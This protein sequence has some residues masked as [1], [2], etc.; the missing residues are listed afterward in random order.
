VT[1]HCALY[2]DV[3]YMMAAM[4]TRV[5][6]TSLRS[7]SEVDVP[8]FLAD[9][10][11]QVVA[12]SGLPLLRINWYDAGTRGG[13]V[14]AAQRAIGELPKVKL[15][16]GRTGFNG[17]QKGVDLKLAL[18]LTMQARNQVAEVVY[19]MSG[20]D[21]LS[22]AVEEAQQVGVQVLGLAIPD[23]DGNAISFSNHLRLVVDDLRLVDD[24]IIALHVRAGR[25]AETAAADASLGQPLA[26]PAPES[27]DR[28]TPAVMAQRRV[29]PA[30]A[31]PTPTAIPDA[32]RVMYSAISGTG[33]AYVD[34]AIAD[35]AEGRIALATVARN[36]VAS[37]WRTASPDAHAALHG[38][39]PSVPPELDRTLL[40]DLSA[41]LDVYDIP[42]HWRYRLREAFWTEVDSMN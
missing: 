35:E 34:P 3:G 39:R 23:V 37:W 38:E 20:D 17:E 2:I 29:S 4:S 24:P 27:G 19:L 28:A 22:E 25:R 18:D 31:A 33:A 9:L 41:A 6:N 21:D 42:T 14:D 36:V 40:R 11:A 12:D 16:L 8:A 15:R 7:A 5:A 1:P 10:S 13:T 26:Q 32:G 30:R